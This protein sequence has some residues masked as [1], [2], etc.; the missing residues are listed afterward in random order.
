ME[1]KDDIDDIKDGDAEKDGEDNL[2]VNQRQRFTVAWRRR[3]ISMMVM[4]R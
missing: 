4:L 3:M 1:E 2:S